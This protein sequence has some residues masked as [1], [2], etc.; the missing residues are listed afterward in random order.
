MGT[1]VII[2]SGKGGTGKTTISAASASLIASRGKKVLIM[3]SDPAHSLSDVIGKA[4]SRDELTELAPN[5][6]GLE[7]DT[8]YEMRKS[9][10]GFQKF[11]A[12]AYE[13][14]GV[15]SSVAAELS[16]QPGMDEILALNRLLIEYK[17]NKWDCIIVD[18]APTGN[19]LR[20]LA[21]PE[22][23]IGGTSGKNF[24]KV[25]RGFSSFVR[26]FRQQTPNDEFFKEVNKLMEMMND[27][28]AF[29]VADDVSVRLVLNPEKLPVMETKR[30][31]TFLSLYGIKMDSVIIN[32][33]LPKEKQLGAYFDYWVE[34]QAKYIKEIEDSFN[35]M[36][37]FGSILEDEEPIGVKK[38]TP[39]AEKLFGASDPMQ[40]LYDHPLI[41]LEEMPTNPRAP[42]E[43]HRRLCV[44][45]PFIDE[46]DELY[47]EHN[48]TDVNVT[49]GRIQRAVSL[50]RVLVHSDLVSF[51]YEDGI[52]KM[53]FS[54]KPPEEIAWTDDP[55]FVGSNN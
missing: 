18:T 16:N 15:D 44:R 27:L 54:E 12:N 21:Y 11:M 37:I 34:L 19:T 6:Y 48:G 53:E 32:K 7:V 1:R 51:Y 45:L 26:P 49:A 17:S 30:A 25:Y 40:K 55:F 4:I 5:L 2:Y 14:R 8:V 28:S 9:M 24:F 41:W 13:G 31:Y 47:I 20:L 52:L 35:P 42:K 10:G 3:S 36:P 39:V 38:L 29:I 22:M 43:T 23:I 46:Q 50:P 33:I